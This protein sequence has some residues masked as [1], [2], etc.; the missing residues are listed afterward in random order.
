VT[1]ERS[2]VHQLEAE[3]SALDRQNKELRAKLDEM[4]SQYKGKMKSAQQAADSKVANLE[5]QLDAEMRQVMNFW[6]PEPILSGYQ[7]CCLRNRLLV[8]GGCVYILKMFFCFCFFLFFFV[9]FRPSKI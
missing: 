9:F 4:E 8:G 2:K 6:T 5:E 3:R 7:R 1:S